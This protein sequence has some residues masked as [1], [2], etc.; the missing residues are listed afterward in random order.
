MR[1]LLTS[2]A[3][4]MIGGLL[5]TPAAADFLDPN[6]PDVQTFIAFEDD[7]FSRLSGEDLI[8]QVDYDTGY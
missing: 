8:N 1:S 2:F 6:D 7:G 3:V 5:A 4:A